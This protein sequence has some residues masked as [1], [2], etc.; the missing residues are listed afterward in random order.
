MIKFFSN[1]PIFRRLFIAFA[2]AAVI[3]G[4]VIILLGNFYINS[5]TIQG[6]AVATSFDAQSVAA[7]QQANLQRMNALLQTDFNQ[8]FASLS[9]VVKDSSLYASGGLNDKELHYLEAQFQQTLTTYIGKYELATSDNMA[10]VRT[11]LLND[12]PTNGNNIITA[13]KTALD[14]TSG[15]WKKYKQSQDALLITLDTLQQDV[16]NGNIP[17]QAQ[18]NADYN[19]AYPTM[20]QANF[21]FTN[22]KIAG[23][24]S[25]TRRQTWASP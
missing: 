15:Y 9:N 21:D 16:L 1:I 10:N 23:R 17:S 3:P 8:V 11:I 18:I 5:L 20:W 22:L 4:I 7:Q 2:V 12:D 19:K 25:W 13:Q 14:N 24:M 6:Q